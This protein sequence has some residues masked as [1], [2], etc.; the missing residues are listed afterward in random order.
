MSD[1]PD[2]AI[3]RANDLAGHIPGIPCVAIDAFARYIAQHEPEPSVEEIIMEA[4][5]AYGVERNGAGHLIGFLA[6]RGFH[7]VPIE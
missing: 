3:K 4:L 5:V 7:I 6:N 1:I 2:W